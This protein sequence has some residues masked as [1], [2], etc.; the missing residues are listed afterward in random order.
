MGELIRVRDLKVQFDLPEGVI[1]AVNGVSFRVPQGSTVALVGESGSG[2]TVVSQS[3]MGILPDTARITN[4][5]IL[6]TDPDR[7]GKVVDVA[8]LDPAG[9]EMRALRGGRMSIIFQEPMT[10]LSPLHTIGDQI[11]EA[12]HLHRK[13]DPKTGREMVI[14]M[15]RLVEFPDP[16]KALKTYSFELSGGLRQRAMIAMALICRPALLIADEPTTALDVTIQ[17]Q[18]LKLMKD[19]Q[20][21][22]G[23][24]VLIITHD[25]GVVANVAEEIIVMYNGQVM[26]SGSLDDIFRHPE[27]PYLKALLNAVPR[28]DMKPGERLVPIRAIS[29]TKATMFAPRQR[30]TDDA[31][32]AGP[33]LRV[34]GVSKSFV[35]RKAGWRADAMSEPNIAVEDVSFDINRGECLGLVGESG[36][37]KTVTSKIIMRA[38]VADAGEVLFNGDGRTTDVLGLAGNDLLEYRRKVQYI[39]QDPFGSLNPRMTVFDIISEPLVIHGIGTADERIE[40]VKELMRLVGLD[41]RYLRRYPHS[42]S[43]GQRQRIGIARALALKPELLICDEP[44]S[45]LDVSI[46]AQVLNLLKDLQRELDLTYLFISHNLAVVDYVADRI[47]VMCAGRLVEIAPR[48]ELF[49]APAHPYTKTLLA[50]VPEPDPDRPLDFGALAHD[51]CSDPAA[52]PAPFTLDDSVKA[53]LIDLGGGHL[54]RASCPVAELRI[55]S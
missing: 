46:Q 28:F 47:A 38:L 19:L 31:A 25:F 2:K 35:I 20:R 8:A 41:V 17:A 53:E 49:S 30:G 37:G 14:D 54:V 48:A 52:W 33:L 50:A 34:R 11:G 9:S 13:I 55:A 43:G 18:I 10:S 4:G 51:R 26:E 44:V 45:A 16:A 6:F 24:A 42:F 21:E 39:F 22:L 40:M 1:T 15:L 5:E 12:L 29:P 27:H 7:P 3:I 36:C 32:A 23:M